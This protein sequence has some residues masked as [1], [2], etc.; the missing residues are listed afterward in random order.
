MTNKELKEDLWDKVSNWTIQEYGHEL[1]QIDP[2]NQIFE[3]VDVEYNKD[4]IQN[5][6]SMITEERF[7]YEWKIKNLYDEIEQLKLKI[8]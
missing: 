5:V 3:M 7:N 8:N 6:I 1:E 4:Q 2:N